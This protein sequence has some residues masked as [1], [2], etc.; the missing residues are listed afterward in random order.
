MIL[1]YI[2]FTF[3]ICRVSTTRHESSSLN[4]DENSNA[5]G[6]GQK[7][8]RDAITTQAT[9]KLLLIKLIKYQ[10]SANSWYIKKVVDIVRGIG[11]VSLK[12][13]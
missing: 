9:S 12:L 1:L 7:G 5:H 8:N 3:S 11:F 13:V 2:L 6:I 10:V 4:V